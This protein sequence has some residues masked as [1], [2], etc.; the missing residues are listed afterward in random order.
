MFQ[1]VIREP[2]LTGR[3]TQQ[4]EAL[5]VE[6]H[7][8]PGDSLP[9]MPE[10]ARQ[11]GV[12]RTVI[13]E[14]IGALAAKGLLEVHHGS[15]TRV[16]HPSAETVAQSM[17]RYLR[18]GQPEIDIAKVSHVRRMLE[19]EIAGCAAERRNEG[20]LAQLAGLLAEMAAIAQETGEINKHRARYVKLD[21]G[22]HAGLAEATHN[23]LFP[24]LL[25]S[26]VDTMLEVR[27]LG[28]DVPGSPARA[29]EFH[30]AIYTA[31]QVGDPERARQAMREHLFDS[32]KVMRQAL[33]LRASRT[34]ELSS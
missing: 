33:A 7:L 32:E 28:F 21:V 16:R 19:V 6:R 15:R 8:Q 14:A 4:L 23:E 27:E 1:S 5:I 9:A 12:S 34:R 29:Q 3:V 11:L 17:M 22:F 30:H 24:L 13:R 25:N 2:N 31:V 18:V 10:L 20:D 26:L